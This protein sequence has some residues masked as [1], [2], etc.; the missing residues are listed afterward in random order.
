ML[1][2][3]M[4]WE[5][6]TILA[7]C[8]HQIVRSVQGAGG[9][10]GLSESAQPHRKAA[11]V[12]RPSDGVS[13]RP[14][15]RKSRKTAIGGKNADGYLC[16]MQHAWGLSS[17]TVFRTNSLKRAGLNPDAGS[18]GRK[19]AF[20]TATSRK[21]EEAHLLVLGVLGAD[22]KD[23]AVALD[24]VARLTVLLD[25]AADLH[26]ARAHRRTGALDLRRR[27]RA[28]DRGRE[29]GGCG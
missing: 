19:S 13:C 20:A 12:L 27:A 14:S 6:R 11:S 28:S 1:I 25:G 7:L 5:E 26:P 23:G 24:D 29:G 22:D 17:S 21:R 16:Y 4:K 9:L 3:G 18:R 15:G 8:C 10:T 2:G